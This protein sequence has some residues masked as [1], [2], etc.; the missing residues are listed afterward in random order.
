MVYE[1]IGNKIVKECQLGKSEG[2]F[3]REFL[4]SSHSD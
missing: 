1:S 3:S 2:I 4:V